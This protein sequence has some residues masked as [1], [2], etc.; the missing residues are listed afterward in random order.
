[1]LVAVVVATVLWYPAGGADPLPHPLRSVSPDPLATV[2]AQT[3]IVVEIEAGYTVS[4]VVDGR[5]IPPDEI[6][7]VPATGTYRWRP[8]SGA[9]IE[10]WEPG[11]HLVEVSWDR[12]GNQV[13]DPGAFAWT[14][15]VI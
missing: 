9:V 4:L 10:R 14:F 7:A 13:P 15:R 11:E 3:E 12:A 8:T 1:L 6:T 5:P 2:A